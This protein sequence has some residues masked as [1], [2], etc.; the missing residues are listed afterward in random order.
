M[1]TISTA[2]LYFDT[3]SRKLL[4]HKFGIS[5]TLASR[6]FYILFSKDANNQNTT[7]IIRTDGFFLECYD[8]ADKV[9]E[10]LEH[11]NA[12]TNQD[13]LLS[14][15]CSVNDVNGKLNIYHASPAGRRRD[16]VTAWSEKLSLAKLPEPYRAADDH[17]A[18]WWRTTPVSSGQLRLQEFL[19]RLDKMVKDM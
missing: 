9:K 13:L 4:E 7:P 8:G 19:L 6:P 15:T 5:S 18:Y 1:T 12:G 17:L 11:N 14:A 10:M 3:E 16:I 2:S